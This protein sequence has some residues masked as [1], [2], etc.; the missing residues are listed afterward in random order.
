MSSSWLLSRPEPLFPG[1]DEVST[2][3]TDGPL[4]YTA[5]G[6]QP[7]RKLDGNARKEWT[8]FSDGLVRRSAQ[9]T[10]WDIWF[11]RVVLDDA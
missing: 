6:E 8:G 4:S 7:N 5:G 1:S 10:G 2:L 9:R 11:S 3:A